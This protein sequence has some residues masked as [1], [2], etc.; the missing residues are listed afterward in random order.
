MVK[1][2]HFDKITIDVL[3]SMLGVVHMCSHA[4][5]QWITSNVDIDRTMTTV[6]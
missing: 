2:A 6:T 5:V 3:R 1:L 4:G